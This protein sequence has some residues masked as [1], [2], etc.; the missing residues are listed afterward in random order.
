[1]LGDEYIAQHVHYAAIK[2]TEER[3]YRIYITDALYASGRM[4]RRWIDIIDDL[5]KP[6][7][8]RTPEEIKAHMLNKLNN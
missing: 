1:M 3:V 8:K 2:E 4:Q 5:S 6:H 7:D